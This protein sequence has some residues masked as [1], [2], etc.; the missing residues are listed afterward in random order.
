M[1]MTTDNFNALVEQVQQINSKVDTLTDSVANLDLKYTKIKYLSKLID[2]NINYPAENDVL[3]YDKTGKWKNA[4]YDEIGLQDGEGGESNIYVIGIGDTT[5]PTN[6]NVYSAARTVEDWVSSKNSDYMW[7]DL[8]MYSQDSLNPGPTTIF[9]DK[10]QSINASENTV[11]GSG[12]IYK[13]KDSGAAYIETDELVVR[14]AAVFNSLEIKKINSVGGSLI[15]S[16]ASNVITRVEESSQNYKGEVQTVWRC[17]YTNTDSLTGDTITTDFQPGDIARVQSFNIADTGTNPD[18]K[19]HYYCGEVLGVG[20][21]T[22]DGGYIDL[23][24]KNIDSS[25]TE[26]PKQGDVLVQFGNFETVSRQN[27]ITIS[28]YDNNAPSIMLYQGVDNFDLTNKSII[29]MGYDNSQD[30]NQ[31]YFN[32]YG[33]MY[34]GTKP[35]SQKESYVKYD[36]TIDNGDGSYGRVQVKADI[37]VEGTDGDKTLISG[38]YIDNDVINTN[39]LITKTVIAD[40]IEV[41]DDQPLRIGENLTISNDG[42]LTAVNGVFSGCVTSDDGVI[43]GFAIGEN[44]ITATGSN[45][46]LQLSGDGISFTTSSA[47]VY[48][49]ASDSG[50]LNVTG[51][52]SYPAAYFNNS[53]GVSVQINGFEILNGASFIRACGVLNITSKNLPVSSVYDLTNS[54]YAENGEIFYLPTYGEIED[55]ISQGIWHNITTPYVL[56]VYIFTNTLLSDQRIILKGGTEKITNPLSQRDKVIPIVA[57]N[58]GFINQYVFDGDSYAF[59]YIIVYPTSMSITTSGSYAQFR[60]ISYNA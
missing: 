27:I 32:V 2:V 46:K 35:S 15:V 17:F 56:P 57:S 43:G 54:S 51:N 26:P 42:T 41:D 30:Q 22:K 20:S 19:N 38:G 58:G 18:V 55:S 47:G 7:G 6:E 34:I 50:L 60:M 40:A 44:D 1:A 53:G 11:T 48:L 10:L 36:P 14:K 5:S 12:L 25:T 9:T 3:V 13:I 16:V 23:S 28:T 49:R 52:S 37:I 24:Q 45:G 59:G 21:T 39:T 33:R 4:Q 29:E 8:T 31:G